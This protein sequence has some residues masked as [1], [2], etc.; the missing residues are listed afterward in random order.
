MTERERIHQDA[1]DEQDRLFKHYA[2]LRQKLYAALFVVA[3]L[4]AWG[5]LIKYNPVHVWYGFIVVPFALFGL[6]LMITP[7]DYPWELTHE[8]RR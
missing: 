8:D 3:I 2:H 1:L 7:T 4:I 5:G 6:W